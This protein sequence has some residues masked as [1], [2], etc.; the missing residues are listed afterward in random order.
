MTDWLTLWLGYA[1][2]T[3]VSAAAQESLCDAF[4]AP[5]MPGPSGGPGTGR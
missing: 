1:H 3:K 5:V 4:G 2:R